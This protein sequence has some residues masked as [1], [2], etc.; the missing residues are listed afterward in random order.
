[1]GSLAAAPLVAFIPTEI[2]RTDTKSKFSKESCCAS[3]VCWPQ[4]RLEELEAEIY[5]EY[6]QQ[7]QQ[8][9]KHLVDKVD[10]FLT[11][12]TKEYTKAIA[13]QEPEKAIEIWKTARQIVE[14]FAKD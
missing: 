3:E 2:V 7:V 13:D 12:H 4:K 1:M 14:P 10:E 6:N 8:I 5:D 9:K 11:I